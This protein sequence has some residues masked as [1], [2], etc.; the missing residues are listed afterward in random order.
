MFM[1]SFDHLLF[2]A[3]TV[4]F[5]CGLWISCITCIRTSWGSLSEMEICGHPHP[6]TPNDTGPEFHLGAGN[7]WLTGSLGDSERNNL[8]TLARRG[9]VFPTSLRRTLWRPA[10]PSLSVMPFRLGPTEGRAPL[11]NPGELRRWWIRVGGLGDVPL[12]NSVIYW[13]EAAELTK[14]AIWFSERTLKELRQL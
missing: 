4:L 3:R 6:P 9:D 5:I 14:R 2:P 11:Q 8:G 7:F 1:F 13:S 10:L 12:L